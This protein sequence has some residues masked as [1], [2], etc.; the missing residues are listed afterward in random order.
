MAVLMMPN[1]DSTAIPAASP[2]PVAASQPHCRYGR[3]RVLAPSPRPPS[4]PER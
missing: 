3:G 2:P 4:T 1:T